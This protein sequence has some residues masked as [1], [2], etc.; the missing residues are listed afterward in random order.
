MV[1]DLSY[2]EFQIILSN[3]PNMP[4]LQVGVKLFNKIEGRTVGILFS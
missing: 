2:P 1:N 4:N 3:V